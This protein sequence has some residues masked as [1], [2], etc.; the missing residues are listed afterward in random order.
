M[1]IK[2]TS[3]LSLA[4]VC[5]FILSGPV[6]A[7][8]ITSTDILNLLIDNEV[9][10][11]EQAQLL[12]D[13]VRKRQEVPNE[14]DPISGEEIVQLL[15][16]QGVISQEVSDALNR[17][18]EKR[19]EAQTELLDK[20]AK[21][22]ESGNADNTDKHQVRIPY[23]PHYLQQEMEQKLK[24]AV[25]SDIVEAVH[26]DVVRTA[27][28]EGWGI[29]EAPSW[30]YNLK[31]SGDG[32]VRYQGDFFPEGNAQDARVS[33]ADYNDLE[34]NISTAD[35]R[36][37]VLLNVQDNRDRLRS[38]FRLMIKAKPFET[39]TLG[40]RF[41]TGNSGNPVSSNQ[42]LG[43]FGSKWETSMDLGYIHYKA[44][45]KDLELWGG[46]FKAPVLKTDLIFD[47][48]M[49]FE[50]LAANY[51]FLRNDTLYEDDHQWDPYI[52][53]GMYPIQEIHQYVYRKDIA[54]GTAAVESDANFNN[55]DDKF[56]YSLQ[57]GTNYSFYNR[58]EL[59]MAASIY[60]Y[61]NLTAKRNQYPD[62]ELQNVTLNGYYQSGN[63]LF[64]I[65]NENPDDPTTEVLGLASDFSLFNATVKYT[66]ANF[67]PSYVFLHADYVKNIAFDREE[68]SARIG[69][70]ST[71]GQLKDRDSG[72]QLGIK[73]GTKQV[74]Y[75][76]DWQ[77]GFTYRH[78]EG[79]AVLDAFADSDF[80]LG[81][82]DAKGFKIKGEYA[83]LDNVVAGLSYIS[84]DSISI[85][86]A[87]DDF[88]L[89]VDTLFLDV[90][91]RF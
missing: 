20:Q 25:E 60:H 69:N 47:N 87:D 44:M 89:S 86:P 14:K 4:L 59:S 7:Q 1:I 70:G 83:M 49:T 52:S 79:D 57:L 51:Y 26:D 9:L 15:V 58:N 55:A 10:T 30:V 39:V 38:R 78:L 82:T 42:T 77:I 76:R 45:E 53:V 19:A 41:T 24:F 84:A 50:G 66:M 11:Q 12:V 36:R 29:K 71:P 54:T 72:Y 27:R 62:N 8:Q 48:D 16:E 80:L 64:D 56:L 18:M 63:S 21:A 73:V 74:Q 68:V 90:S 31:L 37:N 85:D 46:R 65:L 40:M 22:I 34:G 67:F 3:S 75:L 32:R 88:D 28:T 43:Q 2:R 17:K 91:A 81:G 13:D 61:E 33:I 6:G 35:D 23:I 5:G